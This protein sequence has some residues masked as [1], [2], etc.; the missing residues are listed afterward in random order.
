MQLEADVVVV[1]AGPAGLAAALSAAH[2]DLR[3]L[4]VDSQTRPGGT[5][6]AAGLH[7]LCGLY[8]GDAEDAVPV[9]PVADRWIRAV[10][11]SPRRI[12]RVHVLPLHTDMF[13]RVSESLLAAEPGLRF[14]P[15]TFLQAGMTVKCRTLV[16]ATGRAGILE[17]LGYPTAGTAPTCPGL[18]FV[19]EDVDNRVVPGMLQ[20]YRHCAGYGWPFRPTLMAPEPG[21]N[22]RCGVLNL[23]P[24]LSGQPQTVLFGI[25]RDYARQMVED[26]RLSC[27]GFERA[28]L[29]RTGERIGLRSGPVYRGPVRISERDIASGAARDAA[30]RAFWPVEHWKDLRGARYVYPPAAGYGI[31]D[32]CLSVS[33]AVFVAGMCLAAT[34][35]GQAAIRTAGVCLETGH[36]AGLLA[37]R[38]ALTGELRTHLLRRRGV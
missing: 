8:V 2:R 11:T 23:A 10:G 28:R 7:T 34:S 27:P 38:A 5:V 4:L 12:G 30:V 19:L 20:L 36:R 22:F 32:S 33:P 9:S 1:G 29:L 21:E 6:A 35:S 17:L 31:P 3:V 26:L 24:E 18:G 13:R 16:D 14:R 15:R 37:R 25:A